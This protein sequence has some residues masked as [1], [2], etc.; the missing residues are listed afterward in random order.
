MRTTRTKNVNGEPLA[1]L[2]ASTAW[3]VIEC[4]LPL[5]RF[6]FSFVVNGEVQGTNG[7]SSTLHWN[8]APGWSAPKWT[9]NFLNFLRV[10]TFF[11]LRFWPALSSVCGPTGT[12]P[13]S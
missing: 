8:L 1:W 10:L 4:S 3:I 9:V 5:P 12:E 2:L 7:P 6:D 13:S 11:G